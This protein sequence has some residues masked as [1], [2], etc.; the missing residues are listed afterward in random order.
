[1]QSTSI[2]KQKLDQKIGFKWIELSSFSGYGSLK[3]FNK[4]L[5]SF[6]GALKSDFHVQI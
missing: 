2:P 6:T 3:G 4:L 5:L 1:M